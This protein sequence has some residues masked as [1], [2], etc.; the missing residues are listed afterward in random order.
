MF[1]DLRVPFEKLDGVPALQIRIA[2]KVFRNPGKGFFHRIVETDGLR[3]AGFRVFGRFDGQLY[4][5]LDPGS[6]EGAYFHYLAVER[7]G[8]PGLVNGDAPSGHQVRHVEG[9]DDG[10]SQLLKLGSQVKIA[11]QIRRV[12][13]VDD[14]GRFVPDQVVAA[15]DFFQSVGGKGINA[16]KVLNLNFRVL[17][18]LSGF[19]FDRHAG[20]VAHVL[21][22]ACQRV[23][24]R[25]FAAVGVAGK[26]DSYVVHGCF[27][28]S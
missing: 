7:L 5:F 13:Q 25:G 1:H 24:K 28:V 3:R 14:N 9:D 2:G 27:L 22:G 19:A 16:R 17:V 4:Q 18:Q 12:H 21:A 20:P 26:S 15:D 8:Q 6:L 23:E 11:F 10:A